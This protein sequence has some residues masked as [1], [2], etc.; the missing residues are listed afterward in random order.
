MSAGEFVRRLRSYV[1]EADRHY[2]FWLGAGCSVTSDIPAAAAL[3]RDDWLPKLQSI[4]GGNGDC[5]AWATATFPKYEPDNPGALYGAVMN[6]LFPL[7]EERQRETER[8][9][10]SLLL[11]RRGRQ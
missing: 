8:R 7:P 11:T 1:G 4:K 2:V 10:A 9:W 5:E 3:V 6:D